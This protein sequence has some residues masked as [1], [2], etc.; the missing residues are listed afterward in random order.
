MACRHS[1]ARYAQCHCRARSA[2]LAHPLQNLATQ[3]QFAP[4]AITARRKPHTLTGR[5]PVVQATAAI[6]EHNREAKKE[7]C[8]DQE[9]ENRHFFG[10]CPWCGDH[11]S[12]CFSV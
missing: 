11:G 4:R 1:L 3:N 12:A 9:L 6:S 7:N 2:L 5:L 10:R 8:Y